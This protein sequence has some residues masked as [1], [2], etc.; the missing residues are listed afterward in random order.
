MFQMKSDGIHGGPPNGRGYHISPSGRISEVITMHVEF[1]SAS[2]L[3]ASCNIG[4]RLHPAHIFRVF[5]RP[6]ARGLRRCKYSIPI[7]ICLFHFVHFPLVFGAARI[8]GLAT[9]PFVRGPR[10]KQYPN[11]GHQS[12]LKNGNVPKNVSVLTCPLLL[13]RVVIVVTLRDCFTVTTLLAEV[14]VSIKPIA[15]PP[16]SLLMIM[17]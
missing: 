14:S 8:T 2:T 5:L 6:I 9:E 1:P 7:L 15:L 4:R 10:R 13:S 12:F 3:D 17:I 16:L 11:A